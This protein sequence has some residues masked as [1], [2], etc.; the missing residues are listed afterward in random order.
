MKDTT[1]FLLSIVRLSRRGGAAAFKM[2]HGPCRS[3]DGLRQLN[4][5]PRMQ[6]AAALVLSALIFGCV[7]VQALRGIFFFLILLQESMWL[8]DGPSPPPPRMCSSVSYSR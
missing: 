6:A 4:T 5:R 3:R 7:S 2:A 8:S 1:P